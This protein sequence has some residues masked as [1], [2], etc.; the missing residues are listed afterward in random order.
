MVIMA[1]ADEGANTMFLGGVAAYL[2]PNLQLDFLIPQVKSLQ[3]YCV[4][5]TE[6]RVSY[7]SLGNNFLS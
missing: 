4:G 7:A 6:L 5:Q 1:Q 3:Q 2:A